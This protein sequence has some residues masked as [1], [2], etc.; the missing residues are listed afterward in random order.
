MQSACCY[1]LQIIELTRTKT[2]YFRLKTQIIYH[3]SEHVQWVCYVQYQ[4]VQFY[5]VTKYSWLCGMNKPSCG[6]WSATWPNEINNCISNPVKYFRQHINW[7]FAQRHTDSHSNMCSGSFLTYAFKMSAQWKFG[8]T[9]FAA[10][11]LGIQ[12]VVN[13]KL[14]QIQ[15]FW[16]CKQKMLTE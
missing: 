11:L 1:L 4:I 16:L 5:Y 2:T 10:L 6:F 8:I 14:L 9:R 12:N 15:L 13:E 3:V 7:K